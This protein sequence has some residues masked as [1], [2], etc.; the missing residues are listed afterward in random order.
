[1]L[2]VA[3]SGFLFSL[4]PGPSMLYVVSRAISQGRAAGFASALGL[5]LGGAALAV[6]T[7]LASGWLLSDRPTLFQAIKL[8]GGLYLLYLGVRML[9]SARSASLGDVT[10]VDNLPFTTILRQGFTVELLNPK[11]I[12]FFL[13]F[14][15]GFVDPD[16]AS[17][18]TQM[19]IL[20][21][22][23]P[24]T[25]IPSDLT[26]SA[27]GAWLADRLRERISIGYVI[28]AVGAIVVIA[29]GVRTLLS[30]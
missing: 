4:S 15:P 27:G 3:G 17:V 19:L 7:A 24:L 16:R 21:V 12:L 30:I 22:L 25:A 23:V 9:I 13:A 26:V 2:L 11:T 10:D 20:G 8:L 14:L 28:E 29:L 18:T 6:I 5:A 1:M